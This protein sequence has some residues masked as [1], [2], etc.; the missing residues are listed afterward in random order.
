MIHIVAIVRSAPAIRPGKNPT[1]IAVAGNLLQDTAATVVVPFPLVT[2]TTEADCVLVVEGVG[3][4]VV[5][6]EEDEDA[7]LA[8]D[9]A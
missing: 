6:E 4:E 7:G 3:D 9:E 1:R 5:E 8:G 2:G